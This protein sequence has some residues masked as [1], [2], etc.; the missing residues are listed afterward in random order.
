MPNPPEVPSSF[1]W[2]RNI[3]DGMSAAALFYCRQAEAL[4][5]CRGTGSGSQRI[6]LHV[7]PTHHRRERV[8]SPAPRTRLQSCI[9]PPTRGDSKTCFS[10][11]QRRRSTSAA[12][13]MAKTRVTAPHTLKKWERP[14]KRTINAFVAAPRIRMTESSLTLMADCKKPSKVS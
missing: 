13:K 8:G 10:A 3:P 14:V 6:L 7:P 1:S 4:V 12:P 5:A 2:P 9:E 11:Y